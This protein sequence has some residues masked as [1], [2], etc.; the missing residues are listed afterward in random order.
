MPKIGFFLLSVFLLTHADA[1]N[2][3]GP[4]IIFIF[5]LNRTVF[6]IQMT[7]KRFQLFMFKYWLFDYGKIF[8]TPLAIWRPLLIVII[9]VRAKILSSFSLGHC[10]M[11]TK[12]I[13][14]Y[15]LIT[16]EI[17]S[18]FFYFPNLFLHLRL[19]FYLWFAMKLNFQFE[20]YWIFN[21][22]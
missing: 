13:H 1:E 7:R 12:N 5:F 19:N 9:D 15:L 21:E 3:D 11:G 14:F 22:S 20:K 17:H 2:F 6:C 16:Y 8:M 10:K 18:S 4:K